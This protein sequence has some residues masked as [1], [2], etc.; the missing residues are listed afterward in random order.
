M[1]RRSSSL[2]R[3]PYLRQTR[4]FNA[5]R[6]LSYLWLMGRWNERSLCVE[7]SQKFGERSFR[8]LSWSNAPEQH[9]TI[10]RLRQVCVVN[11][12]Q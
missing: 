5:S 7:T 9:S 6:Q 4:K 8:E 3:L 2:C 11:T 12:A 1:T 10:R